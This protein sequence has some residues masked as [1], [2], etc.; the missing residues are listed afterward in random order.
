MKH[1]KKIL[2]FVLV[3]L[4][5]AAAGMLF[6]TPGFQKRTDVYLQDY[7]VSQ[8]GSVI[9]MRMFTTGSMGYIR[10]M[11][12]EQVHNELHCSF[13]SCFGGLN[14][15]LGAKNRFEINLEDFANS[16]ESIYLDRA[17]LDQL[18]LER[19]AGTGEW[20][21]VSLLPQ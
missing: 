2:P 12:T 7:S 1:V 16:A 11:E 10:T 20:R 18:V 21:P 8:D 4:I 9:T 13:Y 14:S 19:D 17:G 3:F 15:S 6:V 5:G